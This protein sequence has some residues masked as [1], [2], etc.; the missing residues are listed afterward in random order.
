MTAEIATD[1]PRLTDRRALRLRAEAVLLFAVAPVVHWVFYDRVG[2]FGPILGI[3][4]AGIVL[5]ALTPG[6][7][8]RE[9]LRLRGFLGQ[10]VFTIAFLAVTATVVAGLAWWLVPA[11][12]LELPRRMPDLWLRIMMFYPLLSVLGQELVY[13]VLF[14]RRYGAVLP[15]GWPAVLLNGL[16]FAAAHLFYLNPVALGLTFAGG[17]AFG[18]LW[19]RGAPFL[20]LVVLHTLAGQ[21]IFSFGLG[22]YFYHGAIP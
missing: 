8:W 13:R 4:A 21:A 7:R 18:L 6:F 16:A 17:L 14:F 10:P 3:F 5:L 1:R 12:F 19:Q 9:L 11:R 22:I 15:S 2:L 20:L